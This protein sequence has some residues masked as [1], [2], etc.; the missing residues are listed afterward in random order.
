[1]AEQHTGVFGNFNIEVGGK[2]GSAQKT[3]P[4]KGEMT[5]AWFVGFAPYNN[6]EI[7]VACII[8]NGGTGSIACYPAKEVIAQYFGMNEAQIEENITAIPNTE[9]E[10]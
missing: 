8:E 6:P 3:D 1:M 7:A 4:K 5:N 9:M 10:N 2:T